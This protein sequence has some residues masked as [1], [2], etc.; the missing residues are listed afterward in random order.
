MPLAVLPPLLCLRALPA[1]CR[2][3]SSPSPPLASA[4]LRLCSCMSP[5]R[6]SRKA[7]SCPLPAIF[8]PESLGALRFTIADRCPLFAACFPRPP[9]PF[10]P[11]IPSAPRAPTSLFAAGCQPLAASCSSVRCPLLLGVS[12]TR[13][14]AG[15]SFVVPRCLLSATAA[16]RLAP[17]SWSL[18]EHPPPSATA[19]R[20]EDSETTLARIVVRQ[21]TVRQLPYFPKGAPS[22]RRI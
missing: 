4:P 22:T 5:V 17:G 14:P 9:A 1:A 8:L 7:A 3:L 2:L 10:S 16:A 21:P 12:V 18:A 15:V 6:P 13:R 19:K 20:R 11:G